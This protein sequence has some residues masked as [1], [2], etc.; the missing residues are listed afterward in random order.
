MRT[1]NGAVMQALAAID[2]EIEA[3]RAKPYLFAALDELPDESAPAIV[4]RT[5][6]CGE[7]VAIG[8]APG[9]GKTAFGVDLAVHVAAGATWF[10]LKVAGGPVVY[11]AAEAPGSVVMRAKAAARRKFPDAPLPLYIVR[12]APSLGGEAES[13]A[14]AERVISTIAE[15]Q[16]D[17]AEPVRLV[18][19]D[20][21]ASCLGDGDEN[22]AGM[23]RIVTAAKL[24]AAKTG[25]SVV[26]IHHPSKGDT[27]G[28]RGH[29][30]LAAAVDTIF[31]IATDE[32]SGVRTATLTK[33]RDSAT[34]VQLAYELEVSTLQEM[35]A[36][37]D[38]RTTVVVRPVQAEVRRPWPKGAQQ[39]SLLG[40]LER[41]HRTGE[42]AWDEATVRKIGRELGMPRNSPA[43]ALRGLIRA[44]FVAGD[45][46]N[47]RLRYAPEAVA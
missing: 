21:L 9:A 47:L 45:P 18:F 29:G 22:A 6:G 43:D 11:F 15:V 37:G 42:T 3:E 10:G 34:G 13:I 28:L 7:V 36:F 33:S 35:D 44:G 25:A 39:G 4:Q 20:T 14:H 30:S 26:L 32:V 31:M 19:L 27:N 41:R 16:A 40:E 46:S 24:I 12:A 23:Q 17:A 38:P 8:G 2:A 5:I 1:S